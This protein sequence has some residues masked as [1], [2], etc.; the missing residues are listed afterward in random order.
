[1]VKNS[2]ANSG[3]MGAVGLI[4]G[5]GKSP[6]EGDSNPLQYS[7]G[8]RNLARGSSEVCKEL[9]MTEHASNATNCFKF[10]FSIS[11]T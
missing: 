6:E 9:D 2:P 4:P 10:H 11:R 8:Q 7:H 3:D 1:M 5:L